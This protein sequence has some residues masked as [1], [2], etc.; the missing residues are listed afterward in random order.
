VSVD[1][2]VQV[3]IYASVVPLTAFVGAYA[4]LSP[5]YRSWSGRWLMLLHAE[6]AAVLWLVVTSTWLGE[7][8]GR[9][10][11]RLA[12]Y[13]GLFSTFCAG[14]AVVI[15][16]QVHGRRRHRRSSNPSRRRAA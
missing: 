11:V 2:L 8:P 13:A 4:V 5:W 14:C 3:F 6:L 1:V 7:Y 15:Y 12:V 10:Y 16:Q 9:Q